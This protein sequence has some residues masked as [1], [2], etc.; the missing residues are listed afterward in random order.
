MVIIII[1]NNVYQLDL[2]STMHNNNV[3]HVSLLDHYTTQGRVQLS[4]GLLPVIVNERE[5]WGVKTILDSQ[6]HYRKV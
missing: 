3:F 6:H 5:E 1:N 4:T 2:P